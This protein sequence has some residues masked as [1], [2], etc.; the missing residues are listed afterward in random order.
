MKAYKDL[1]RA[2]LLE[3][4]NVTSEDAHHRQSEGAGRKRIR[5]AWLEEF[6]EQTDEAP[7]MPE[8]PQTDNAQAQSKNH[9]QI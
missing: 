9:E 1:T 2:E 8:E 4:A 6:A 7:N 5:I 3:C